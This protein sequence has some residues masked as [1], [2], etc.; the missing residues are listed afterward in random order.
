MVIFQII[1]LL[2]SLSVAYQIF[3]AKFHQN[4]KDVDVN[5][6]KCEFL[7]LHFSF[8]FLKIHKTKINLSAHL[9]I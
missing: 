9:K 4:I 2:N 1:K 3:I 6:K 8:I 7:N 5:N